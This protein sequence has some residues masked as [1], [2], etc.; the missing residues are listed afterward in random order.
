MIVENPANLTTCMR[1]PPIYCCIDDQVTNAVRRS[2]SLLSDGSK[3]YF[4]GSTHLTCL[5][6]NAGIE[7]A[8]D[9]ITSGRRKRALQV[10]EIDMSHSYLYYD[11]VLLEFGVNGTRI[12]PEGLPMFSQSCPSAYLPLPAGFSYLSVDCVV[13][14]AMNYHLRFGNYKLFTNNCNT[15]TN[16]LSDILCHEI[17]C[18]SWC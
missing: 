1:F 2:Y 10:Q 16:R 15:F 17:H 14:C 8:K 5:M 9:L 18:P 11:G 6:L 3:P 4:I 7:L 12:E 13:K